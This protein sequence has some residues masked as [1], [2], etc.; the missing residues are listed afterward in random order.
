LLGSAWDRAC[1]RGDRGSASAQ[2]TIKI[3]AVDLET[4]R[5]PGVDGHR[6][7]SCGQ[8][9]QRHGRRQEIEI[10]K[11]SSDAT[12]DKPSPRPARPSSRT[13]STS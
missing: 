12:P 2:E 9:T 4:V 8:A 13:R 1:R 10:I 6:G 11:Y 3:G 5:G 7:A